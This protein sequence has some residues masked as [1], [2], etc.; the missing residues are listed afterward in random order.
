[1]KTLNKSELDVQ[2]DAILEQTTETKKMTKKEKWDKQEELDK[3][4]DIVSNDLVIIVNQV[5]PY[6]LEYIR[7]VLPLY[8]I[9]YMLRVNIKEIIS[10]SKELD[11]YTYFTNDKSLLDIRFMLDELGSNQYGLLC[12]F[13]EKM[14][15]RFLHEQELLILDLVKYKTDNSPLKIEIAGLRNDKVNLEKA[16]EAH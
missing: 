16:I 7:T 2:L 13:L 15:L 3:L 6:S 1:M 11:D 5:D 9:L 10:I 12:K 4:I 8:D 14:H